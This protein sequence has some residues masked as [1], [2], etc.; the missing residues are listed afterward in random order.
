MCVALSDVMKYA[1]ALSV[2]LN[3]D[4]DS[5]VLH[6]MLFITPSACKVEV[7]NKSS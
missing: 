6:M 4:N 3:I 7:F 2:L 5:S 1:E